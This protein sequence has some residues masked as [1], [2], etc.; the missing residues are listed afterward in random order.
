MH[1]IVCKRFGMQFL[2][3]HCKRLGMQWHNMHCVTSHLHCQLCNLG[4][5]VLPIFIL[6]TYVHSELEERGHLSIQFCCVFV[7]KGVCDLIGTY[8][9]HSGL[10]YTKVHSQLMASTQSPSVR[11]NPKIPRATI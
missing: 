11:N 4:L 2:S 5:S 9:K 10:I 8:L 7:Q 6:H 3:M 1:S